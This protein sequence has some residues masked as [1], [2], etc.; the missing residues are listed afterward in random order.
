MHVGRERRRN[1]FE[2]AL[3]EI[4]RGADGRRIDWPSV[5]ANQRR[6]LQPRSVFAS[7]G[8]DPPGILA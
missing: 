3:A 8:A 5:T 1:P 6:R 2:R 7:H 4:A